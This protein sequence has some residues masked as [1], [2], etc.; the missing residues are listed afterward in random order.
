MGSRST[1]Y[2]DLEKR[3]SDRKLPELYHDASECC[4]CGTCAVSCP[5][6]A[7]VMQEDDEG[8]LYPAVKAD[9][10]I[11]CGK[12]TKVCAFQ[13]DQRAKGGDRA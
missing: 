12:C 10:C 2:I 13:A 8:F 6:S 3:T 1:I 9:V 7:I 5:V 4:G 11:G